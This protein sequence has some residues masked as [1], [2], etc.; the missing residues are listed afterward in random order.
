MAIG[1][2]SA[3]L[4]DVDGTLVESGQLITEC[5]QTALK[6]IGHPG[7]PQTTVSQVVGPPLAHSFA[8]IAGLSA[9]KVPLAIDSYRAHYLP[10]YL[11]P[12]LYPGIR[13]LLADL[14][15]AGIPLATATSKMERS[16]K[17]QLE[18]W[19]IDQYF[20]VIAGATPSPDSTK[21]LVVADALKRLRGAGTDVENAVLVG[22]RVFDVNGAEA[23]G[24][25]AIAALWGYGED[26]EFDSPALV[27]KADSVSDLRALLL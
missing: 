10:R 18:K 24:I 5:F 7:L 4:F 17:R 9:E 26:S 22:D 19:E 25:K 20:T 14:H 12:P 3:V 2:F 27:A 1:P 21:Q 11:E 13:E 6:E 8:S 16:A 15:A 23:N